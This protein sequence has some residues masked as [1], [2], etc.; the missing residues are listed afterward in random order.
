MKLYSVTI[1][2]I[3]FYFEAQISDE[4]YKLI[5]KICGII[6]E[7]NQMY[8]AE[9]TFSLFAQIISTEINIPVTPI[10][11]SHVFRID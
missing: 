9:D 3:K 10:R 7:E 5:D 2:G 4:Q 6:Q 8:C 11:I 1:R